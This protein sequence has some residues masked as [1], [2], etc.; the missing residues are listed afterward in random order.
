MSSVYDLLYNDHFEGW[1]EAFLP[2]KESV[3]KISD[4]IGEKEKKYGPYYPK[5]EDLFNCFKKTPLNKVKVVVWGQDP[6]Y[7]ESDTGEPMAQGY[8][9]GV[10]KDEC[11]PTTLLNIYKEIKSN[12]PVFVPPEHGD[13]TWL[14][15]Q[16]IL[17]INSS[18]TIHP[19]NQHC[20]YNNLW[21]RFIYIV[22]TII[23][24]NTE[25]CIHVLWGKKCEKLEEHIQSREVLVASHPSSYTAKRGFFGCKHFLKINIILERQG[26]EQINW[27]ENEDLEKTF[28]K[29][30]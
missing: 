24:Q 1:S 20:N 23:N 25:N 8:A 30:T 19:V 21:N 11:V 6:Y 26:K 28:M 13:L 9:F 14:T 12:F 27:N 2:Y 7:S 16:G 18:M 4:I 17:F 5:K 22:I 15:D 29:K 10:K 3:K